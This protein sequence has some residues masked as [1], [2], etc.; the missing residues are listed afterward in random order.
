MLAMEPE[1]FSD[2]YGVEVKLFHEV[3]EIDLKQGN[4]LLQGGSP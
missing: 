1:E 3:R 4:L 2:K